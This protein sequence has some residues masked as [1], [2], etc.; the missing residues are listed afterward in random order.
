MSKNMKNALSSLTDDEKAI[1]G[2][3][4]DYV[5][6]RIHERYGN[7]LSGIHILTAVCCGLSLVESGILACKDSKQAR[8]KQLCLLEIQDIVVKEK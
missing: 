5:I 1:I 3:L 8:L 2:E 4:T 6:Q 7:D